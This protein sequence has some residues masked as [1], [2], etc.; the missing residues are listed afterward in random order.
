MQIDLL[1]H[2]ECEGGAIF[3][4]SLDVALTANGW[5]QMQNGLAELNSGWSRIV[6]SPLLRCARFAEVQ[7]DNTGLPLEWQRD[8][9][10]ICFGDWEG[11]SVERIWREQSPLCN[12]WSRAP[13]TTTPPNGEPFK[14]FRARVLKALATL[15]QHYPGERLLVITHGGVIKLLLTE[16]LGTGAAGMMQLN[17]GYGFS[18][19][20]SVI[21]GKLTLLQPL[22]NALEVNL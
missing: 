10:E 21:N 14:Q 13:D 5:Q 12:A 7:A 8:L 15:A 4:G 11:Q 9:R 18:T 2:G 17:V 22:N 3:R 16:A 20:M 1:R 19:S 6:S